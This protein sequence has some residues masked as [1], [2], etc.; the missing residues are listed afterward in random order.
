MHEAPTLL[1]PRLAL[2][3]HKAS[4]FETVHAFWCEP[5]VYQFIAGKPASREDSWRGILRHIGQ[6]H[7]M[8]F[9]FW[10]LEDPATGRL[11][12]EAG[13]LDCKRDILP[14]MNET[15]EVGW[16]L[17]PDFHGKGLATEALTAIMAWGDANLKQSPFACMIAPQNAASLRL[18]QKLGFHEVAQTTYKGEPTVLLQRAK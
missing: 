17:H 18:A 15:P 4:D 6:W 5:A 3:G 14:S 1:T 2:R 12:G 8:G 13:F 7:V 16:A 9:G 11:V 10:I